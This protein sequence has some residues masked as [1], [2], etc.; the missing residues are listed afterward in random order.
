MG[1]GLVIRG[2][3]HRENSVGS[4]LRYLTTLQKAK[5]T[6]MARQ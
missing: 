6:S 4:W 1:A 2:V 3:V 5:M